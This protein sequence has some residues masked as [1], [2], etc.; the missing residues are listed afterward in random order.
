MSILRQALDG[1]NNRPMSPTQAYVTDDG[2]VQTGTN[3]SSIGVNDAMILDNKNQA[4]DL[5]GG[6]TDQQPGSAVRE[7]LGPEA[8]QRA[9]DKAMGIV[10]GADKRYAEVNGQMVE[11]TED[12][13]NAITGR[14]IQGIM[15]TMSQQPQELEVYKNAPGGN[16]MNGYST[17]IA[18]VQ[19]PDFGQKPLP[20]IRI[21]QA[22]RNEMAARAKM[23]NPYIKQRMGDP[24]ITGPMRED[25][26]RSSQY[27]INNT[28]GYVV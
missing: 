22:A 26:L 20:E 19:Q 7:L 10:T 3:L 2:L 11:L 8:A 9:Q 15:S 5:T 24:G 16:I 27:P 4:Y 18:S 14:G 23:A 17:G 21:S 25:W 6:L 13:Y 1:V 12:M 28:D